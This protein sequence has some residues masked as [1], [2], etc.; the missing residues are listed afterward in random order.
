MTATEEPSGGATVS[1][2]EKPEARSQLSQPLA[3]YPGH[4][5]ELIMNRS[6]VCDFAIKFER[7]RRRFPLGWAQQL[8]WALIGAGG[9]AYVQNQSATT[10]VWVCLAA[11]AALLVGVALA[12]QDRTENLYNLCDDFLR[13]V[14]KWPA[15]E[16]HRKNSAYV[17]SAVESDQRAALGTLVRS[18][19]KLRGKHESEFRQ[20]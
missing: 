2:E 3:A 8:G 9:G 20:T 14:D 13:F 12:N 19:R 5:Q 16:G 18:V 17:L 11:G 10:L 7:L 6:E 4:Q 1:I 15:M